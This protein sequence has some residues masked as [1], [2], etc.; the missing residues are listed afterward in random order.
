MGK[1]IEVDKS[2]KFAP[3]LFSSKIMLSPIQVKLP[4]TMKL[5]EDDVNSFN[6]G[7]EE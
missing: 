2:E 1:L 7:K 5:S 4:R 6:I 3:K